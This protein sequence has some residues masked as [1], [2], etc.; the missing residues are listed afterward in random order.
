[1]T[2]PN[3]FM[4]FPMR[5]SKIRP[6][7]NVRLILI[8]LAA[9]TLWLAPAANAEPQSVALPAPQTA[10]GKPLMQALMDRQS[11]RE[12]SPQALPV[13]MLANLLWAGCGTNRVDGR[14]TAP[15]TMNAQTIDL[16]VATAQGV[17]RYDAT[18]HLL[19][20][21]ASGDMR[22]K[23]GGQEFVKTAPV[24]LIFVADLSRLAKANPADRERYAAIDAGCI[25]QNLYLFCASEGL[26]TVVHEMDRR[27]LSALLKLKPEQRIILAQ[28]VGYPK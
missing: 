9:A 16:Y 6:R 3:I 15:S 7:M 21:V 24:A 13:P 25:A 5:H 10:T 18:N 2:T 28:S 20:P 1:M 26:A 4:A 11:R 14:R 8:L 22:G 12:F 17:M 19:C 27:E 23:T